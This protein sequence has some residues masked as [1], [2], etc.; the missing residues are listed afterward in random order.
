MNRSSR[1][2]FISRSVRFAL[3]LTLVPLSAAGQATTERVATVAGLTAYPS[4]FHGQQILVRAEVFG[5]AQTV[6][7]VDNDAKVAALAVPPPTPGA[8]DTVEVRGVFWDVGRLDAHDPRLGSQDVSTLSERLLQKPWPGIGELPLVVANHVATAERLPA[9][10]VG[11]LALEPYRY[12]DQTV[13]VVGRFRGRNLYGDLP[14]APGRS[15]WDFVLLSGDSAVWVVGKQPRGK[16]FDLDVLARVDT[17]QWLE[18]AGTVRFERAMVLLEAAT[19]AAAERP[20]ETPSP[21]TV[22]VS[23]G[24]RP[25]VV[26][27]TPVQDEPGIARDTVVRVQFSR[28]INPDTIEGRVRISYLDEARVDPGS[29]DASPVKFSLEYR[30]RNRVLEIRFA[31]DLAPLRAVEVELNDG[32]LATDG[33]PLVPWTLRFHLGG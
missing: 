19:L 23:R 13:T 8:Q 10:T 20:A 11:A 22:E 15:R 5:D 17:N 12:V 26:F 9:T 2:P 24:P 32:I 14:E 33:A 3:L 4:F 7:L 21:A 29:P 16:G 31:E 1:N 28:D 25:E 30:G 27:S 6:W 18:V